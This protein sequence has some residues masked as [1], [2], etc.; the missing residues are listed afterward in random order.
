MPGSRMLG[1]H[2]AGRHGLPLHLRRRSPGVPDPAHRQH[3]RDQHP[4]DEDRPR[5]PPQSHRHSIL[6]DP[7]AR[8]EH[9]YSSSDGSRDLLGSSA[10]G[11]GQHPQGAEQPVTLD[12]Q[13]SGAPR[14]RRG[15]PPPSTDGLVPSGAGPSNRSRGSPSSTSSSTGSTHSRRRAHCSTARLIRVRRSPSWAPTAPRW[16][17][18]RTPAG[19]ARS[20]VT[21]GAVQKVGS[22]R[23]PVSAVL[24]RDRAGAWRVTEAQSTDVR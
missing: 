6:V 18:V 23:T 2:P 9:S 16:S 8:T 3:Q 5:S 12:E 21:P 14:R 17:T 15:R 22:A 1:H 4:P 7:P 13:R 20:T 19:P 10:P 24:R 11:V